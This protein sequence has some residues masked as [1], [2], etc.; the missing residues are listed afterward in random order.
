[1]ATRVES[2][3]AVRVVDAD[4]H[5]SPRTPEELRGYLPEP[6][7]SRPWSDQVFNAIGSPIYMAPNMAQRRDA[8]GPDGGPP[9]SDPGFTEGQ[10]FGEAGVDF[11]IL[12]PLTV[13]P[14]TNPEHEAA[15]AA[16]T[17]AWMADTWLGRYNRHG[18]YR[19][20]LRICSSDPQLGA[21]EI[22]K[23]AGHPGFVQV[24]L[25]P[26]ARAPYGQAMYRPIFAAAARHGLPV[27]IHVN[28]SPGQGLM[29]PVGFSSYFFEHHSLYPLFYASHLTSI[30]AEGL[31]EE[32]PDL[33][34]VLVEGGFSWAAPLLWR[35]D[36]HWE[37]CRDEIPGCRRRPSEYLRDHIRFTS[38]PIEE[39]ARV[40]DL[41]RVLDWMDAE[42]TLLFATDY[43]HWD[44]DDPSHIWR[45]LPEGTRA[46]ILAGNARELYGLPATRAAAPG[47]EP[48]GRGGAGAGEGTG[49]ARSRDG[50]PGPRG[51]TGT[52]DGGARVA[53]PGA[54]GPEARDDRDRRRRGGAS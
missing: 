4:V 19:G 45:R 41:L 12:I 28:R 40:S 35:L 44:Y 2:A 43:P 24:M 3:I 15:V 9:A 49:M 33:K 17:N 52:T 34:L 7:R 37:A 46:R 38:Q 26:Y 29:T 51:G 27:A 14:V 31:F 10:L 47:E 8:Y 36:R 21:A 30:L 42:H 22:E 1:M 11:A 53:R 54:D 18:R 25:I 20:T 23:W 6:W 5:P 32:F 39:P 48:D 13:R 50:A 16:A